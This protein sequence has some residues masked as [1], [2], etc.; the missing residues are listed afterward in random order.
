MDE[1]VQI[2]ARLIALGAIPRQELPELDHPVIRDEVEKRLAQCGFA[3]ASSAYSDHYGVRLTSNAD[4]SVMDTTSNMALG[5]DACA[6][7]AILWAKLALQKRTAADWQVT[8]LEQG[9]LLADRRRE[10][11]LEFR[12]SVRFETL[13]HE[14]GRK[15]GGRVRLKA[16]LG[17]LR[18]LKF[19]TYRRLDDIQSGPLL[20]LAID[21]EKMIGFIRSRV[22]SQYLETS[23]EEH[24][25]P[26]STTEWADRVIDVLTAAGQPLKVSEIESRSGV[27]RRE[28]K[29]ALRELR[30]DQRVEAIGA[31]S[32]MAYRIRVKEA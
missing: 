3:L 28:L 11:A 4:A 31:G 1:A 13:V 23:S 16:M 20:E 12:P 6:L 2:C 8:P 24:A 19:I 21:G 7:I 29:R 10:H 5:A 14:F 26:E 18:K 15:L 25:P 9:E 30:E 17:H 32:K 22:L 27:G